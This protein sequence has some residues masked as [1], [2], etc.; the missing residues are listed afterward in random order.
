[1]G[2]EWEAQVGEG[3]GLI[4]RGRKNSEGRITQNCAEGGNSAPQAWLVV[5]GVGKEMGGEASGLGCSDGTSKN[6]GSGPTLLQTHRLTFPL[7]V[8]SGPSPLVKQMLD[9]QATNS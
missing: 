3:W 6:L 5:P 1:M 8:S 9:E 2:L 4:R 7:A